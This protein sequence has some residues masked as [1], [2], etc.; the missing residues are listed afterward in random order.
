MFNNW[1]DII[2]SFIHFILTL[3]WS[4]G[5]VLKKEEKKNHLSCRLSKI[6]NH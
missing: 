4:G 6:K 5:F 2:L 3:I 1:T